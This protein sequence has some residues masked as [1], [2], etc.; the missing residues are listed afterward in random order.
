MG[1][2]KLHNLS[3]P[4]EVIVKE[5]DNRFLQLSPAEKFYALLNLNKTAVKLNG[6]KPLKRPQGKGIIISKPL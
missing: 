5:R 3:I 2:L 1:S 6:G 4:R